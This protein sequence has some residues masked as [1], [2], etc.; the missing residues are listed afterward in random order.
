VS[1]VT[2]RPA[3]RLATRGS[4]LAL[5]Q[6]RRVAALLDRT[7]VDASLVI[8]ETAGDRHLDVSID[9]LGGQGVFVKEVQR[10][11]VRGDADAAVHSAKD[12]PA[13]PDVDPTGLALAAFPERADSRDVLV[14]GG[15]ATLPTGAIV[16][17]GSARRR[18]QLAA[19]RPDLTF[20]GLRG[21]LA[22]RLAGVGSGGIAA[23]VAAKA[24][25]DRLEW[26][27]PAGVETEVLSVGTMVPQVGQ[28]ALAVECRPDD[29]GVLTALGAIDDPAVTPLVRAE[30]AYLAELGGGC[31][32]PVGAHA[33][34]AGAGTPDR[35][36]HLAPEIRLEA[37]M[38]SGDGWIVLRH[39][40]TGPD[41]EGLGRAVA[42]YL[43][44]EAGGR[45]LGDWSPIPG[46][47][48]G[49]GTPVA[50]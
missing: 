20:T 7:G 28:G 43:L 36:E 38:A 25:I 29:E 24:A 42:R 47:V 46:V 35:P 22:R 9:R 3:L 33:V 23:V 48:S 21:N 40:A 6:A 34:W 14:G 1:V 8:V 19:L 2:D 17:T 4:P 32:Q 5:W 44:D 37:M 41:P 11:V 26:L 18:A 45:D 39:T 49:E 12:L 13:S 15:L 27:A 31:T 30:R 16:A 50:P 10:A